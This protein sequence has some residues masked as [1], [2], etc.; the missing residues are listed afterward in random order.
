MAADPLIGESRTGDP[1]RNAQ[2]L[3]AL[4]AEG[5]NVLL[6][7]TAIDWSKAG[8]TPRFEIVYRLLKLDPESGADLGRVELRYS[9][10]E[11]PVLRSVRSLW[12]I[13]DWL[14][15][16]VWDMFG[17]PFADRPDIK[18][19]LMYEEFKGHPLRKDYPL[20]KRQPLI[21]PPTGD[22]Q[23]APSFTYVR[24]TVVGE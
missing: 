10:D 7:M 8:R 13:A 22:R 14:E 19:L 20:T 2:E 23:D 3:S 6:D 21:G 1:A 18:R 12:P 24:P 4:K 15:R 17:V 16:E 9:V 5:F 11:R